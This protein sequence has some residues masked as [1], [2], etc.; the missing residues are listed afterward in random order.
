MFFCYNS[1][2]PWC[3]LPSRLSQDFYLSTFK[4]YVFVVEAKLN[5][6]ALKMWG[7]VSV[8]NQ[9][10]RMLKCNISAVSFPIPARVGNFLPF[11]A[12]SHPRNNNQLM[13]YQWCIFSFHKSGHSLISMNNCHLF[14]RMEWMSKLFSFFFTSRW[15]VWSVEQTFFVHCSTS[16]GSL[17]I[18]IHCVLTGEFI[19]LPCCC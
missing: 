14:K 1:V 13:W 17:H 8:W 7:T 10:N 3:V 12:V 15:Q 2:F 19:K 18:A 4:P 9:C 6:V 16:W 5:E 11:Y